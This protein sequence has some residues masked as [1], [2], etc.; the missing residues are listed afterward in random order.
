[1][2]GSLLPF[3]AVTGL[4]M[5][6]PGPSVLFAVTQRL[7]GGPRA[8]LWAVLGLESGLSVHVVAACLGISAVVAASPAALGVLRVGGAAYLAVLGVG[9]L[10]SAP[11]VHGRGPEPGGGPAG[12]YRA[13][14]MVDLLNPK[15]V[16]YVVA[17]LPQFLHRSGDGVGA[18]AL[19]LGGC[20]V[21]AALV[22]DGGYTVL[23]GYVQ[24]RVLASVGDAAPPRGVTVSGLEAVARRASGC[25]FLTLAVVAVLA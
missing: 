24:R 13:G 2:T 18:Q 14:L 7:R 15:T 8:G 3:L 20:I 1:M 4:V 5:A 17:L 22:C 6:A 12:I 9:L 25:C 10:R 23:A 11:A 16:L 21:G 19:L